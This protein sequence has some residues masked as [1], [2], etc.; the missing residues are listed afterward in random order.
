[1]PFGIQVPVWAKCL[2]TGT[3]L[4]EQATALEISCG[5][6]RQPLVRLP[7]PM[8]LFAINVDTPKM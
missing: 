1:M 6:P 8:L 3:P 4:C 5:F 2:K 7:E